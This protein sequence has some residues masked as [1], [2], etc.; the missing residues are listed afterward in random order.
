[1]AIVVVLV[2]MALAV[3]VGL[4]V[5]FVGS[6]VAG[7]LLSRTRLPRVLTAIFLFAIPAGALGAAV[8]VIGIGYLAVQRNENLIFLGPLGGLVVGGVAGLLGGAG[9]GA[10]WARR[11]DVQT[12]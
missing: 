3:A 4:V 1:M 9:A 12:A 10:L 6:L 5:L 8:G 7:A 2:V 11:A